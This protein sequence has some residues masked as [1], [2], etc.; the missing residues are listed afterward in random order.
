V[1][2]AFGRAL[3]KQ[4]PQ[5]AL[6]GI[7]ECSAGCPHV[8]VRVRYLN[9]FVSTCRC[10]C[11]APCRWGGGGGAGCWQRR[12][13]CIRWGVG[14]SRGYSQH[15]PTTCQ[16]CCDSWPDPAQAARLNDVQQGPNKLCAGAELTAR[17]TYVQVCV[18]CLPACINLPPLPPCTPADG[19]E[20]EQGAGSDGTGASGGWGIVCMHGHQKSM[21]LA[22]PPSRGI[23]LDL[24]LTAM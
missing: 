6:R 18:Q 21:R 3:R 24:L 1:S 23:R 16:M 22:R 17:C 13:W 12:H 2:D 11:C 19:E 8:Q 9:P 20:E 10:C 5:Q 7:A 15:C 14:H 4:G